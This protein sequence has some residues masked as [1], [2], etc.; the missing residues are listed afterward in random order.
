MSVDSLTIKR[1][2]KPV[3]KVDGTWLMIGG[4]VAAVSVLAIIPLIFLAWQSLH[5]DVRGLPVL[6]LRNYRSAYTDSSTLA[7]LGNSFEFASGTAM[8]AFAIGASLAWVNERTNA[9]LKSLTYFL[10]IVPLI[11]PGLLFSVA[12]I[13]LANPSNG[14]LNLALQA[15]LGGSSPYLNI[16]SMGGMIWVDALQYAPVAFLL[17]SAALRSM[18]PSLEES[19]LMSGADMGRVARVITFRLAWPAASAA[20]LIIFVRSLESFE[21]PALL[22]LPAGVDVFTSS[23]YNAIHQF[24]SQIGLASTYATILIALASVGIYMHSRASSQARKY[25]TV[26]GKG[27][28]P[29]VTELGRW[30]YAARAYTWLCFGL[31]VVLPVAILLWASFQRFYSVPSWSAVRRMSLHTYGDVLRSETILHAFANSLLVAVAAAT[32]AVLL[33]AVVAWVVVKTSAPGR[34]MLEQ[35]SSVPLV[36]PG[37]VVGLAF[38]VVALNYVD[39]IYGTLWILLIAFVTRFMP[40]AMQYNMAAIRQV[41]GELEESAYVSGAGWG[42]TFVTI[43]LPLLK[44]G[45]VAGWLFVMIVSMRELSSSIFLYGPK[46]QLIATVEWD[47]WM[48][49]HFPEVCALGILFV[50]TLFVLVMLTQWFARKFGVKGL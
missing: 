19:A 13:L 25:A 2:L 10:A 4:C 46:T 3:R 27:F 43:V 24:P 1:M 21:V 29:R 28:R 35:V 45:L 39:V 37:I 30:K 49:G 33:T 17:I 5:V 16:Y 14:V 23:I 18:D 47:L 6:T 38:M 40:Y 41:H 42:R 12:W 20:L 32:V 9:G 26:T 50:A 44:P 34:R 7:M 48:G 15:L 11:I 31:M 8:L 22:G 36:L